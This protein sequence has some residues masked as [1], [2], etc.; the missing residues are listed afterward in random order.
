MVKWGRLTALIIIIAVVFGLIGTTG[1]RLARQIPLGLDLQG[2]FDVLYQIGNPN[3]H[4][5]AND[6]RATVATIS[7]RVN[8]L[9]VASPVIQVENGTRVNVALAGSFNQTSVRQLLS[10][11]ANLEFKS[12]AGKV[13]ATGAD[14]VSNAHYTPD[15]TTQAPLVAVQFKNPALLQAISQKYL[16]KPMAIWFDGKMLGTP[17]TIKQVITGGQATISGFA[18]VKAAQQLAALL[19]AGALPLPLHVLSSMSV[20]PTLGQ[21]ALHTTLTAAL[22]AVIA[23]FAFMLLVYRLPGLIAIFALCAY[24][25]VLIAVFAG[26]PVTLTLTGLAALVLGIGM[27][28]DANIITYERIKDELRR[29]RSLQSAVVSGQ[30]KALR[31]ILDS[32][33]TTLI[34][35]IVMYIYGSGDVQGFAVALIASII[36]SLVT[37]VFLSRTMLMLLTRSNI[38][39]NPWWFGLAKGKEVEAK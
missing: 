23:I 20:G 8:S 17:P 5:T 26:F 34:A 30:R 28:V 15:P 11:P 7:H 21:A 24:S 19:N 4:V 37:A 13:L 25:Y 29:G 36:I 10:K 12:M 14:L 38:V 16:E 18:S 27:A 39:R 32:N 3:Q 9:G 6:V 35:G 22:F 33:T 31:T 1:T 2:G